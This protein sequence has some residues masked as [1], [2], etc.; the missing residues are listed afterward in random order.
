MRPAI[1]YIRVSTQT[2]GQVRSRHRGAGRP[3][4][5]AS[6]RP[7]AST[8]V[9]DLH[10][11]RD[12]QG[13]R[14]A[15]QAP[16]TAAALAAAKA[17]NC[18]VIVAKLDRLSRDVAFIAGLMAQRVPFIVA[19]LGAE[20]RPVHAA[21]L[22]GARR[23]GAPHDLEHAP[24]RRSRRPVNAAPSWEPNQPRHAAGRAVAFAAALRTVVTPLLHLPSRAIAAVL[25]ERGVVTSTGGAWRRSP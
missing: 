21:H 25:N 16:A 19:E 8:I 20:R 18:P 13:R 2:A 11:G 4:S 24:R 12:R 9:A 22:R 3:P 7:K 6:P 23:A 15:R 10:R 14:R 1:A 17:A 5:C